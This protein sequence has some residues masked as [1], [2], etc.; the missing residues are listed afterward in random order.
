MDQIELFRS[1]IRA[2]R[3][4]KTRSALT[5]LGIIIGVA[6]V[7]L[8]VSIGNGLQNYVTEQFNNL[9]ANLVFVVPGKINL[10][11][12]SGGGRPMNVTSKFTFED[13]RALQRMGDPIKRVSVSE[14]KTA[15]AKFRNKAYDITLNGADPDYQV[16]RNLSADKGTFITNSMVQRSQFAAVVGSKVVSNLFSPREDPIGK[17]IDISG[18]KFKIEGVMKATGGGIGGANDQDSYVYIPMS[19]A[20]KMF[21]SKNPGA[22]LLQATD[23]NNV[24][25]LVTRTKNFF[26]RQQANRSFTNIY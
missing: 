26:Y 15:T 9:G 4:N 23:A 16:M 21:G 7:I 2:I 19:T 24:P 18:N 14:V 17:V 3:T 12:G 11:G 8:L 13:V 1:S 5:A 25:Q 10:S 20:E 6:S 22:I